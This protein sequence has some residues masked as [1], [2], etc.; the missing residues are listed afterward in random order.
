M[1]FTKYSG[2]TLSRRKGK[3]WKGRERKGKEGKKKDKER[4]GEERT[5]D[6]GGR[7]EGESSLEIGEPIFTLK[8]YKVYTIV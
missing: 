1:F 4:K 8:V 7:K 5:E 6:E 2:K 3:V